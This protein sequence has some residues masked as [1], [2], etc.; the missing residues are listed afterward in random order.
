MRVLQEQGGVRKVSC[1]DQAGLLLEEDL[2]TN[3]RKE[4]IHAG[5]KLIAHGGSDGT[6]YYH[7]DHLSLPVAASNAQGALQWRAHFRP[8]GERQVASGSNVGSIGYTGHM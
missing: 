1:Y 6:L 5:G 7:N 8:Y 3:K 2:A 4:Y